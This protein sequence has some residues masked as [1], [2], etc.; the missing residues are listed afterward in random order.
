MFT[1][2]ATGYIGYNPEPKEKP[3]VKW[4]NAKLPKSTMVFNITPA[5]E[6]SSRR[7]GFCQVI[8][9]GGKCYGDKPE[10]AWKKSVVPFRY[11]QM[12]FWETH[13][14]EQIAGY[15]I[16]WDK[17]KTGG[18]SKMIRFN[19]VG[20]VKN[21]TDVR[22]LC[23][24]AEI[25]GKHGYTVQAYTARKDLDWSYRGDMVLNG[26]GWTADNQFKYVPKGQN[27]PA[28]ELICPG[29]CKVCAL[30]TVKGG[31]TIYVR[32]H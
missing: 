12:A 15:I 30:C 14:A 3:L 25:L 29:D 23:Q 17:K 18:K 22:K 9:N 7:L 2:S 32:H 19:E 5:K 21:Q 24:I 26:S 27:P 20:E 13:T 10:R 16:G 6:C 8:N 28:G 11:T 1:I 4:G 31:R